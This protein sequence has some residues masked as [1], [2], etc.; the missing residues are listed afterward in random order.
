MFTQIFVVITLTT[1]QLPLT[2]TG[3]F[4]IFCDS[5]AGSFSQLKVKSIIM[6]QTF[7]KIENIILSI[8]GI[9]KRIICVFG[10]CSKA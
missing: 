5:L 1:M 6:K 8:M 7:C 3:Q 4:D 10:N 2:I 9:I